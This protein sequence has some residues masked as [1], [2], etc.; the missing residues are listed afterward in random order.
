MARMLGGLG[1]LVKAMDKTNLIRTWMEAMNFD[2]K[3]SQQQL[4]AQIQ[5]TLESLAPDK[6]AELKSDGS[7]RALKALAADLAG[8]GYLGLGG[9]QHDLTICQEQVAKLSPSLFM[10]LEYSSRVFGGLIQTFGGEALKAKLMDDLKAGNIIGAVALTEDTTSLDGNDFT[11]EAVTNGSG[12]KISGEKGQVINAP[13]ADYI[14]VAA[15]ASGGVVFCVLPA[16]S[17]GLGVGPRLDLVG[18]DGMAVAPVKLADCAVDT[19]MVIGPLPAA[20]ILGA[21]RIW[22]DQV[23]TMA[24][25]GVLERG[26]EAALAYAKSHKSGGKPIIAYQEVGFKLAEMLTYLQSAQLL[27]YRS[28]WLTDSGDREAA[29]TARSAKVYVC[30]SAEKVASEAMQ[31]LG[32]AGF[33]RGNPAEESYRD[34]KYL[35]V[36]GTSSE[37]SRMKIADQMLEWY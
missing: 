37:I 6:L 4:V 19:D 20:E 3:E 27:A 25:L 30:E 34:A 28:A 29:I 17:P 2:L 23:L 16:D 35:T 22:E 10:G 1:G 26:Y 5:A 15:A 7:G 18:F 36:A 21:L 13:V 8:T 33:S 31:I 14:A 9:D 24:A 11:T 32:G 12:M